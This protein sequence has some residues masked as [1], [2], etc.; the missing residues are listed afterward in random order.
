MDLDEIIWRV[1]YDNSMEKIKNI[2]SNECAILINFGQFDTAMKIL[3]II[4]DYQKIINLALL[5]LSKE[6]YQKLSNWFQTKNSLSYSDSV[7]SRNTFFVTESKSKNLNEAKEAEKKNKYSKIFDTYE[8]EHFIVGANQ[9]KYNIKSVKEA[10]LKIAK[11]NSNINNINK[12]ILSFGETAFNQFV[13]IFN[14]ESAKN[15]LSNI[16]RLVVQKID[17]YYG[18]KNTVYENITNVQGRKR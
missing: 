17:Q 12:K 2:L 1:N 18:Y 11:K 10:P 3:E 5:T 7:F 16:C 4:G 14:N 15:E 8:G 6:E 13:E 9:E